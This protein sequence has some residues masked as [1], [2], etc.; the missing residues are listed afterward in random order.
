[1]KHNRTPYLALLLVLVSVLLA[2]CGGKADSPTQVATKYIDALRKG[3]S[4]TVTQL[5]TPEMRQFGAAIAQAAAADIPRDGKLHVTLLEE[6][7]NTARL[8]VEVDLTPDQ[9]AAG[10]PTVN[11]FYRNH[12][13]AFKPLLDP[14][15]YH[16]LFEEEFWTGFF[17]TTYISQRMPVQEGEPL[18]PY[19]DKQADAT[20]LQR[21]LTNPP[22]RDQAAI[23]AIE[24]I[25]AGIDIEG[26][27]QLDE[28]RDQL[29]PHYAALGEYLLYSAYLMPGDGQIGI[30]ADR[31]TYY[32][33]FPIT[34]HK[35]DGKWLVAMD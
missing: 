14:D 21:F 33:Q 29:R 12:G 13:D 17:D 3:D 28:L 7:G 9:A 26:R 4:G 30:S 19:V 6:V 11:G 2:A 22:A 18:Y 32:R 15:T 8:S 10:G 24:S 1:M 16:L 20:L 34:L 5:L 31:K 25:A 23:D 35:L 27:V